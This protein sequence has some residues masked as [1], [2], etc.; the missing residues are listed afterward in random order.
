MGI[1]LEVKG[2]VIR[3]AIAK[4]LEY[5]RDY[6]CTKCHHVSSVEV[7]LEQMY[8]FPKPPPCTKILYVLSPPPP[9]LF[10]SSPPALPLVS[11]KSFSVSS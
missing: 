3:T 1:L 4:T 6:E 10:L 8:Q 9:L 11:S 7:Q 5:K 2:T